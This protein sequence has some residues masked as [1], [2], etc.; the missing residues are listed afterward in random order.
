MLQI[1]L[2]LIED[3]EDFVF[4][5]KRV[6]KKASYLKFNIDCA[7]DAGD[8]KEKLSSGHYDVVLCDYRLP[9]GS[10]IDILTDAKSKGFI[11]P[12][13]VMTSQGN[14]EIAVNLMKEGAA[15]YIVKD[16]MSFEELPSLLEKVINKFEE[17]KRLEQRRQEEA[18]RE[19]LLLAE[20]RDSALAEAEK[21]TLTG[22]FNRRKLDLDL[23]QIV[24]RARETH[25]TLSCILLDVDNFKN[26][27]DTQGH[28]FGD[29]ILRI[30]SNV[31]REAVD[32]FPD[33]SMY[34]FGGDEFLILLPD[35]VIEEAVEIAERMRADLASREVIKK[36]DQSFVR[37]IED[38]HDK[39][40]ASASFGVSS[41]WQ[42]A[43]ER[44]KL[45]EGLTSQTISSNSDIDNSRALFDTAD[46]LLYEAKTSG[47]N[48]VCYID[49]A[50]QIVFRRAGM[51]VYSGSGEYR[52]D[53]SSDHYPGCTVDSGLTLSDKFSLT[54]SRYNFM[55]RFSHFSSVS[56]CE[57]Y[58]FLSDFLL[59]LK[60]KMEA[61]SK[62]AYFCGRTFD[63]IDIESII[64]ETA[65]TMKC[66]ARAF[67]ELKKTRSEQTHDFTVYIKELVSNACS[68][69]S[70]YDGSIDFK[71]E[72]TRLNFTTESIVSM[73]I[74]IYVICRSFVDEIKNTRRKSGLIFAIESRA[75]G[76]VSLSIA[77]T[78][79][80]F[81]TA[82]TPFI[83]DRFRTMFMVLSAGLGA[84]VDYQPL[85]AGKISF[86]FKG[87]HI[88]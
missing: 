33:V 54:A 17:S 44:S 51:A 49:D 2:L 28:R 70:E 20:Q 88:K 87:K 48:C 79:K 68:G 9:G 47:R 40:F 12:F 59:G 26:I 46:A 1:N 75:A 25:N 38:L 36:H 18:K 3:S 58:L 84:E 43:K 27:N 8:G 15:D 29:D 39:F 22:L 31:I 14:E 73:A 64:G 30:V 23:W 57:R 35:V 67:S 83:E 60:V 45:K 71:I 69:L 56:S 66:V 11:S 53:P 50:G 41:L 82:D 85:Q 80:S 5:V 24:D 86:L 6:L 77:F 7:Y 16:S 74:L 37:N 76:A 4:I 65:D 21:D 55:N 61:F 10:A 34:R 62:V 32:S 42:P 72:N 78:G 19:K 13:V 52:N 63:D 81:S